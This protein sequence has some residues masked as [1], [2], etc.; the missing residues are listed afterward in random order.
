MHLDHLNIYVRDIALSR[1][2]YEAILLPFGYEVVRDF[3]EIAVGFGDANYAVLALVREKE[4]IQTTH[5]AFRV[6]SHSEV[7]RF[8]S[9]A[10][11]AGASNNG[12]PET[13]PHYHEHYYAAFVRDPDGHNLEFVCHEPGA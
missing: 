9:L 7:D 2:F 11:E 4:K 6:D 1:K 5:F 12:K 3:G 8:Y 10:L 13:R